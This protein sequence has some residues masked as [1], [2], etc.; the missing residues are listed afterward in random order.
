MQRVNYPQVVRAYL[1]GIDKGINQKELAKKMGISYSTLTARLT[2]LRVNGVNL[3]TYPKHLSRGMDV[4]G[5]NDLIARH[6]Q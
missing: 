3:P 6:N 5:L 4:N 2:K 1:E